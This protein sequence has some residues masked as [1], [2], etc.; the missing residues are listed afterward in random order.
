[1][2]IV[3]ITCCNVH[4][5]CSFC[6]P[7]FLVL[8]SNYSTKT[9]CSYRNYKFFFGVFHLFFLFLLY[10]VLI[11]VHMRA[12][13]FGT[14]QS[15]CLHCASTVAATVFFFGFVLWFWFFC[16]FFL[17]YIQC[18]WF[19]FFFCLNIYV[20]W[21]IY[22]YTDAINFTIFSQLLAK[23]VATVPKVFFSQ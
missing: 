10:F 16:L 17:I 1:M 21:Y 4:I 18:F 12:Q 13:C 23:T 22:C 14:V 20:S 9:H 2:A 11:K 19:S 5:Q 7:I 8:N 15:V 6:E 3:H